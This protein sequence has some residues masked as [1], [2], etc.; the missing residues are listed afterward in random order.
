MKSSIEITES[1]EIKLICLD[2]FSK[3]VLIELAI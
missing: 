3:E 1:F 2:M